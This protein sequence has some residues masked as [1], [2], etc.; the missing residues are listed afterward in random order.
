MI[1]TKQA[2]CEL[3]GD[4][5]PNT[6]CTGRKQLLNTDC[7]HGSAR[8]LSSP[9][10]VAAASAVAGNVHQVFDCKSQSIKRAPGG[11]LDSKRLDKCATLL[12][13]NRVHA[14]EY[15][16]I[17]AARSSRVAASEPSLRTC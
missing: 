3:I 8:G 14:A 7:V 12:G 17:M 4:G 13:G 10:R 1:L 11:W 6:R 15:N 9:V 5:F 16:K 2:V